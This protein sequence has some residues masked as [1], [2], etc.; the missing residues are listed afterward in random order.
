MI[1]VIEQTA[2]RHKS[3]MNETLCALKHK[4]QLL[5]RI[6]KETPVPSELWAPSEGTLFHKCDD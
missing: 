1:S 6:Q 3:V 2:T 4:Q 5:Q